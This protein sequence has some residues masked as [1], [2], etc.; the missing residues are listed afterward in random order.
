[1]TVEQFRKKYIFLAPD[2]YQVAVA[3][4]LVPDGATVKLDD[5]ALTAA[6]QKIGNSTW[7]IVREPLNAGA[8]H[9]TH[10]L[11]SDQPIGLQ[12]VAFGHATGIYYPGGLNLTLI[13]E[14]PPPPR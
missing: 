2:D 9:G 5:A 14:P 8:N 13:T 7:S 1:V 10:V 3:D 6:P 4:I 11:T 12:V